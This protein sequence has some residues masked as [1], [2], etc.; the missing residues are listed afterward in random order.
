VTVRSRFDISRVLLMESRMNWCEE[1]DGLCP[2]RDDGR[3]GPEGRGGPNAMDS[4][5][6]AE[7]KP[8]TTGAELEYK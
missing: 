2:M 3:I 8:R 7:M 6:G 5:S 4:S 1:R